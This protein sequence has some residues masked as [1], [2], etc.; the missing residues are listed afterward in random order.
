MGKRTK[1]KAKENIEHDEEMSAEE[2]LQYDFGKIRAATNDFSDS[3][4]LGQGG[5]GAVYMA[6]R[7]W[8]DGTTTNMI[9]P[10]LRASSG[11]LQDMLRYINIG[12]LCVQENVGDRPIM[13]SVVL[14]LN[15]FSMTLQVLS[16]LAIFVSNS[17]DEDTLIIHNQNSRELEFKESSETKSTTSSRNDASVTELYVGYQYIFCGNGSE[18][19]LII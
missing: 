15:S 14:M 2:S 11:S 7:N 4:K 3:S 17:F 16:Q 5:F 10:V 18:S 12:L 13:A 1:H 6:W 9:D 19:I 8:R